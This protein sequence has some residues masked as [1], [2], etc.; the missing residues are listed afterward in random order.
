MENQN[1]HANANGGFSFSPQQIQNVL[2]SK[3]GQQLLEL[4]NRDGGAA[5][6]KAAAAVK[7]G[8]YESAKKIMTP[9]MQTPEAAE[10]IEQLNRK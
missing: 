4:L 10:L 9:V 8:D 5:L 6:R 2:H 7:S 1:K 3:Q